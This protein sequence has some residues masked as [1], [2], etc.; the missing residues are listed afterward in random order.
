M[1]TCKGDESKWRQ[2]LPLV[3]WAE[4]ITIRKSTSYSP[5]FMVH[6]VHPLLPF[7]IL[8]AT[9]LSPPQ[10]FGISTE[11]LISLRASQLMKRP[12]DI[13]TMRETV[14]KFRKRAIHAF[15]KRLGSRIHD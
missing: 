8:E 6:G 14:S 9:Y 5:Y 11:D 3:F 13:A 2:V 1:K 4:R 7:D 12:D 15:E 10:D